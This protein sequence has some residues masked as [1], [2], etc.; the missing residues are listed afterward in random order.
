MVMA[1]LKG[2]VARLTVHAS[3][4]A[5]AR[6]RFAEYVVC[7]EG[8]PRANTSVDEP[9]EHGAIG[10]ITVYAVTRADYREIVSALS[11]EGMIL[12]EC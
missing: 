10:T 4:D 5:L 1:S 2:R 12:L 6:V 8:D 11:A 9:G 3:N 7:C